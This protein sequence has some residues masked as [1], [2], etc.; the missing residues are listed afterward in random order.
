MSKKKA[1]C[2]DIDGTLARFHDADK[3]FIEAMWTPGFYVGLKP[4]ESLVEAVRLFKERNPDVEVFTLSAVLDTDPPFVVGEKNKWLDKYLSAI[5][6]NHRIFTRA[7]ED[8][9]EYID[10]D[11][12]DWTLL[13]DYNKNLYEFELAG[14]HAIKFHNDVNHRGLGE[15]GGSKGNLWEGAIVH[16][17]DSP[18]KIC[19]DLE[20]LVLGKIRDDKEGIL[21][22]NDKL[23][24]FIIE[25]GVLVEYVGHD[26]TV[27]IPDWVREIGIN[28]FWNNKDVKHVVFPNS[29]KKI[30]SNA[31]AGVDL[32]ELN[33]P[34]NL[35]SIGFQAFSG[36][37]HLESVF[38][39]ESVVYFHN[40]AFACCNNL[41]EINLDANN[42]K[43]IS[44]AGIVYMRDWE[45]N[46]YCCPSG[47]SGFVDVSRSNTF[48]RILPNAFMGCSQVAELHLSKS[49]ASIG[50]SA[51][52]GCSA[53]ERVVVPSLTRHI[54][55]FAFGDCSNLKSIVIPEILETFGAHVFSGCKN[56]SEV[57]ISDKALLDY[58]ERFNFLDE[59]FMTPAYDGLCDRY[60]VLMKDSV[61]KD[62]IDKVLADA[63]ERAGNPEH[64]CNDKELGT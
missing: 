30:H 22:Q 1:L 10:M 58:C 31:F 41:K 5:D 25:D 35:E 55:D 43:Y 39:P 19:C 4:F 44:D 46:V 52:Y 34:N 9:S 49:L 14:G 50:D 27:V 40:Q 29:L 51:F 6:K 54:Q 53:L 18:E 60:E 24:D 32:Q 12:F 2:V 17:Y 36:C 33:L 28:A 57:V 7:G 23:K 21:I 8:K 62:G 45:S 37:N 63:K 47:R 56:L 11:A 61:S 64:K 59:L 26:E 42:A 15:F 3:M 13:D 16:H 20:E 48:G 38:I